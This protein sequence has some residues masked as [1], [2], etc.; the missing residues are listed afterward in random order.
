MCGVFPEA[1]DLLEWAAEQTRAITQRD[2]DTQFGAGQDDITEQIDNL[3]QILSQ[4]QI[5]LQSLTEGEAHDIVQNCKKNPAEAWR[6][7]HKR[8]DP[9]L[10]HKRNLL[11]MIISPGRL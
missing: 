7:L 11:R 1:E 2:V 4:F 9:A 3:D 10:G 8:F 6:R 5:V